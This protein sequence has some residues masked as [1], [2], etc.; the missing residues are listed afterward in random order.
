[1]K[2]LIHIGLGKAGST[3]L[4]KNIF[5]KLN[6]INYLTIKDQQIIDILYLNFL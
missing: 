4:Q 3:T 6:D 5:E 1:M 2:T